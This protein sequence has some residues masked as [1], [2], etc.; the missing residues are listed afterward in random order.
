M[1]KY[2]KKSRHELIDEPVKQPNRTFLHIDLAIKIIMDCGADKSCSLKKNLGFKIYDVI[3]TKEQTII[4]SIKDRF[5]R[6]ISKLNIV[7][8]KK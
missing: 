5:E 8:L 3:N 7:F 2:T 6:K 4:N 1:I